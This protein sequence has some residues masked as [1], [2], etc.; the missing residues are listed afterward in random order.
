MAFDPGGP[1]RQALCDAS[2]LPS[3]FLRASAPTT[4]ISRLNP[5]ACTLAVY[6]SRPGLPQDS[7]KTRFR[8]VASLLRTGL[9]PAGFQ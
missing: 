3:A 1:P 2:V 9:S 7:R 6:A 4:D 8:L 5:T